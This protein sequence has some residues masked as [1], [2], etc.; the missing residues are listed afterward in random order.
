MSSVFRSCAVRLVFMPRI[1]TGER[2]FI[3][4]GLSCAKACVARRFAPPAAAPVDNKRKASRRFIDFSKRFRPEQSEGR[5]VWRAKPAKF[6]LRLA[7]MSLLPLFKNFF[8][9]GAR[10][11]ID[12]TCA[13]IAATHHLPLA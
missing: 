4:F 13:G 8:D 1:L 11:R 6:R 10:A 2:P 9:F 7:R 3:A 5:Q 12:V